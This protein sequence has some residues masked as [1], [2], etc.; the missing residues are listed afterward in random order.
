M[1]IGGLVIMLS[2]V[3]LGLLEATPPMILR[4]LIA[5]VGAID[6]MIGILFLYAANRLK[7]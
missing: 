2:G 5:A 7:R 3:L 1:V 6:I 4:I